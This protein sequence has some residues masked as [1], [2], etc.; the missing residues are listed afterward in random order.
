M[1]LTILET[2]KTEKIQPK[3][4]ILFVGSVGE[5]GLGD[6]RGSKASF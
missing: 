2:L 4:N 1:L 6:L 3:D 5:E